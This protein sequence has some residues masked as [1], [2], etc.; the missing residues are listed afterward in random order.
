MWKEFGSRWEVYVYCKAAI[1]V[2]IKQLQVKTWCWS[3]WRT[4]MNVGRFNI[5]QPIMSWV[6]SRGVTTKLAQN[7]P[8]F[9]SHV[10]SSVSVYI[11]CIR[12]KKF[13]TC[14]KMSSVFC[15][16]SINIIH[17]DT[18]RCIIIL[19]KLIKAYERDPLFR[20]SVLCWNFEILFGHREETC[21]SPK[22]FCSVQWNELDSVVKCTW[23]QAQARKM[24]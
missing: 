13:F 16:I 9:F 12:K 17:S 2:P 7:I 3:A 6:S 18:L 21:P 5:W 11:L 19:N 10:F 8:Q 1:S 4:L 15:S 22:W 23:I 24:A 14:Y 20:T